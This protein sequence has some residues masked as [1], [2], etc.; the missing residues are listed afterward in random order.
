MS[1]LLVAWSRKRGSEFRFLGIAGTSSPSDADRL[2]RSGA[3]T[4]KRPR[5]RL[6]EAVLFP[7]ALRPREPEEPLATLEHELEHALAS[8][9]APRCDES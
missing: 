5:P 1:V 4:V 8:P 7:H 3:L 2:T 9:L 6:R